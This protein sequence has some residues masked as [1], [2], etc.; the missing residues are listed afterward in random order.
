M[1]EGG[2]REHSSKPSSCKNKG[3]AAS[4]KS[5]GQ[6]PVFFSSRS[7]KRTCRRQGR[8]GKYEFWVFPELR[9]EANGQMK[10]FI[11]VF[12]LASIV[13]DPSLVNAASIDLMT[14]HA[15]SAFNPGSGVLLFGSAGEYFLS[16][17]SSWNSGAGSHGIGSGTLKSVE[18]L[19]TS[20]QYTF[21]PPTD[22]ILYRHT[23]YNAGDHSSQGELG[24]NGPLVLKAEIG[25]NTAKMSGNVVIVSNDMTSYGEPKFNYF[26]AS[27]GDL[28]RY[29]IT[30]TLHDAIWTE[31]IFTNTFSYGLSGNVYFIPPEKGDIDGD[32]DIDLQDSIIALQ[33]LVGA[34]PSI[35][36]Y[37][38]SDIDSDFRIGLAE[39][40]Y[41]IQ[42][43]AGF[44]NTPPELEPIGDKSV[45]EN[46]TLI[47]T[48]I[49]LDPDGD[50][51]TYKATNLPAGSAFDPNSR[52]FT[53][54]PL[55]NQSGTYHVIFSVE[56]R[57]GASDSE[58]VTI[59]VNDVRAIEQW[60]Y[61][62][63]GGQGYGNLTFAEQ[64][65]G[66]ITVDGNWAY[67]Y[68]GLATG[69]FTSVPVTIKGASASF[70][71]TGTATHPYVS[72]SAFNLN[73]NIITNN[74]QASGTYVMTFSNPLWHSLSGSV[75]ATRTNGSGI[76]R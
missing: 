10:K 50:A 74:G 13:S 6:S 54:T 52:E 3:K 9:R 25:S 38:S 39:A 71:A 35:G 26:T 61:T 69:S 29:S 44:Y 53:W 20:I 40:I 16:D 59:T 7:C 45:D 36:V 60:N 30:Y 21:N 15:S 58:T 68:S 5:F 32:G 63:D 64:P 66:S 46:A 70:I 47:I 62:L 43:L 57:F 8:K 51:L 17:G 37:T 67:Y 23:E 73:V 72:P 48:L 75:A 33:I 56:D 1:P 4:L 2:R 55:Q 49:G 22:G 24:V 11:L 27:V 42:K 65:G 31:N 41:A 76:T 28:A 19:G 14:I 18:I 34:P 12:L